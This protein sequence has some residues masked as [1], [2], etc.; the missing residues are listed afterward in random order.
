MSPYKDGNV[1]I[2]HLCNVVEQLSH[3]PEAFVVITEKGGVAGVLVKAW[4]N[5][6]EVTCSELFWY[7]EEKGHGKELRERL[8]EFAKNSGA[9][10]INFSCLVN[11]HEKRVRHNLSKIGYEAVEIGFRKRLV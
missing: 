5:P 1:D 4:F 2:E 9:K 6:K 3:N 10:M 7:S 8:E 11:E